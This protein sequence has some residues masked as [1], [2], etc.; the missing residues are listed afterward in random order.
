MIIF[1][2]SFSALLRILKLFLI[3]TV[4]FVVFF[5]LCL[6]IQLHVLRCMARGLETGAV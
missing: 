6:S 5:L 1:S 3:Q 4:F 2:F